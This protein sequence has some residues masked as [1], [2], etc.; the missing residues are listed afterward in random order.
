LRTQREVV[1]DRIGGVFWIVFGGAV[2]AISLSFEVRTHLGATFVNGPGFVP[3]LLGIALAI[4]GLVL[5]LRSFA[6]RLQPFIETGPAISDRRALLALALMLVYAL[7]FIGRMPFGLATF[8]FI[9]AFI[10]IFNM[11]VATARKAAIVAVKAGA[12]AAIA[13]VTIAFVFRDLFYIRLP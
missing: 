2:I 4:L 3:M 7:G 5:L 10:V 1:A 13:A 12:T 8:L 11:P 6:G 9:T